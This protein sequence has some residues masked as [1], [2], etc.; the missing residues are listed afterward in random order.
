MKPNSIKPGSPPTDHRRTLFSLLTSDFSL[1]RLCTYK[2]FIQNEPNFRRSGLK[3]TA[4]IAGIY[5]EKT[6]VNQ[7][8][9]NP[10]EPN[11]NPIGKRPKIN[12]NFCRNKDLQRKIPI[13]VQNQRTQSNPKPTQYKPNTNP[14]LMTPPK[15]FIREKVSC[16][17][18]SPTI[19]TDFWFDTH[20]TLNIM[21]SIR[22][23]RCHR[24]GSLWTGQNQ[25]I[26][27]IMRYPKWPTDSSV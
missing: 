12:A 20:I 22:S 27:K 6:R 16:L 13:A 25:T 15:V 14:I 7:K 2:S 24:P 11:T 4:V 9:T 10:I 17:L 3:L 5:N 19:Y 26:I 18:A 1:P 23:R 21:Y 8:I